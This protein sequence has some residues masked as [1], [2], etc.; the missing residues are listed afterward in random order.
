MKILIEI[1]CSRQKRLKKSIHKNWMEEIQR[2]QMFV[3]KTTSAQKRCN[4]LEKEL[5]QLK[6]RRKVENDE[7]NTER[8]L[9][10][11][12]LLHVQSLNDSLLKKNKALWFSLAM[13]AED[14]LSLESRHQ[15]QVKCIRDKMKH[16]EKEAIEIH[17][18]YK[19]MAMGRMENAKDIGLN[20]ESENRELNFEEKRSVVLALNEGVEMIGLKEREVEDLKR[21]LVEEKEAYQ[22]KL[23]LK[24]SEYE[25]TLK[26]LIASHAK[27]EKDLTDKQ[28]IVHSNIMKHM[29][30][31]FLKLSDAT[32]KIQH[33][34]SVSI[35]IPRRQFRT[36]RMIGEDFR[37]MYLRER[38]KRTNLQTLV[39]SMHHEATGLKHMKEISKTAAK[40][41]KTDTQQNESKNQNQTP[42]NELNMISQ[43]ATN[44][45]EE[46]DSM[47]SG[48]DTL[49]RL[50]ELKKQKARLQEENESNAIQIKKFEHIFA[51]QE[52]KQKA[53]L[54][55]NLRL[56]NLL[57]KT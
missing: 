52:S 41:I 32:K 53:L 44:R 30:S 10:E 15:T 5:K 22:K 35:V 11:E 18:H 56:Q 33:D 51:R 12:N 40:T 49:R 55:D 27:R 39:K 28:S 50:E 54:E 21:Q 8:N 1:K 19:A 34:A 6:S 26:K 14:R 47:L 4:Y 43:T 48:D 31:K 45:F 23:T 25:R 46:K 38:E 7:A 2:R 3:G 13:G 57:N 17:D 20:A 9:M 37:S 24:S 36:Y 42:K 29:K 16:L